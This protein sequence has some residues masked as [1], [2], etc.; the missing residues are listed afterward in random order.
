M[1]GYNTL[2]APHQEGKKTK[3]EIY[4]QQ[5]HVSK[6]ASKQA[7][8]KLGQAKEPRNADAMQQIS[9]DPPSTC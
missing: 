4:S 3:K 2:T 1:K 8:N 7:G 9:T 5:G 6:Q